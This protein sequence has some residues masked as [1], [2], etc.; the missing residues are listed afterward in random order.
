MTSDSSPAAE[1]DRAFSAHQAGDL[2][3]ARAGYQAGSEGR[4]LSLGGGITH[5]MFSLDYAFSRLNGDL[6]NG[7]T[8][9]IGASFL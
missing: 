4:G 6:G 9:S 7:H 1:F 5:G 8:I 2:A 3:G